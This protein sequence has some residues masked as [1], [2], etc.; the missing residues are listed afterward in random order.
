[1]LISV[2]PFYFILFVLLFYKIQVAV[3]SWPYFSQ[4]RIFLTSFFC[5][6]HLLTANPTAEPIA[7]SF[8]EPL[9]ITIPLS[10]LFSNSDSYLLMIYI[11][12]T[13]LPEPP[14]V[15]SGHREG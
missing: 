4:V 5:T 10:C 15:A 13:I 11:A 8:A 7:V 3:P 14:A 2:L 12:P 9:T 1:M 6:F